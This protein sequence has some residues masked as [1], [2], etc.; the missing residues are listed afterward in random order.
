MPCPSQLDD[1]NQLDLASEP[2]NWQRL[3]PASSSAPAPHAR[4][5]HAAVAL[6]G[7]RSVLIFGGAHYPDDPPSGPLVALSDL[8]VLDCSSTPPTW[9]LPQVA[10]GSVLPQ[11]RNAAVMVPLKRPGAF[12]LHG[13][14]LPFRVTFNDTFIFELA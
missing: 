12:V 1:L 2:P 9:V 14:W 10:P 8:H 3:L 11:A 4:C 13:G 5:S 6:P 7:G